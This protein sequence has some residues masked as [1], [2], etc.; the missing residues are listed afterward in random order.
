MGLR[1][2]AAGFGI[3]TFGSFLAGVA[4]VAWV[5]DATDALVVENGLTMVGFAV[6]AYSLYVT[7][8]E[9]T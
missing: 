4:D 1:Y 5:F 9:P 7:R 6:I 2:L 3:V 8:R